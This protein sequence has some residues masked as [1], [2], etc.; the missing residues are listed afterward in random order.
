MAVG[1]THRHEDDEVEGGGLQRITFFNLLSR[2][3]V[4]SETSRGVAANSEA[5]CSGIENNDG[6]VHRLPDGSLHVQWDVETG[7][8]GGSLILEPADDVLAAQFLGVHRFLHLTCLDSDLHGS[9]AVQELP[10]GI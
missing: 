3:G 9:L 7:A 5:A 1:S 6:I 10:P 8:G 2:L 4:A